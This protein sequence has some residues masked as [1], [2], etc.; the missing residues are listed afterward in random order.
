V[1]SAEHRCAA[2]YGAHIIDAL[3]ARGYNSGPGRHAGYETPFY[4]ASHRLATKVSEYKSHELRRCK[5]H[6]ALKPV[7]A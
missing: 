5:M 6:D 1:Q 4:P 7:L 2:A 3:P